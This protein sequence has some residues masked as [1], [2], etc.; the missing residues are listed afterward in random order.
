VAFDFVKIMKKKNKSKKQSRK[1]SSRVRLLVFALVAGGVSGYLFFRAR[2]ESPVLP[3]KGTSGLESSESPAP[4]PKALA[5]GDR[6]PSIPLTSLD[7]EALEFRLGDGANP[8][9]LY[10]FSPTCSICSKTIPA[11][12]EIAAKAESRS[13][14]VVGISMMERAPTAQYINQHQLPWNVYCVAGMDSIRALRVQSVP[15]TLVLEGSGNVVMALNGQLSSEQ[16]EAITDYL[17]GN[18]KSASAN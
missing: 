11:W 12:K 16:M 8:V 15:M 9:L 18:G 5:A 3:E 2:S 7:G 4:R 14:E 17:D 13:I 1:E 6:L 10:L